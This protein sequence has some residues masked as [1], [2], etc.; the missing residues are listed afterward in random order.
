MSSS[1]RDGATYD[2]IS[3]PLERIGREV[4]ERLDLAGDETVL[5][6]GCGSGRVTEALLERVP[7]G[8]VIGVDGS[9]EMLAAA[10]RRLGERVELLEQDLEALDLGG[11]RVDA[12]L[13]TAT[14]HW[15]ADHERLFARLRG[16]LRPGGQ[17]VAQCGGAGNTPELVVA[18]RAVSER[19]PF[20]AHLAGWD[21]PWNYADP[22]ETTARLEAA[23]FADVRTWLVER[24]TPYDDLRE[25]LRTNAL[26]AHTARLPEGLREAYI[27][28]VMEALGPEG[29]I[30]YVRLN[31]DAIAA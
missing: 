31:L 22:T 9:P 18:T 25:W 21:G 8:H 28:A 12:I 30:T 20:A 15:L 5:D 1:Y 26:T 11:R 19:E 14:F 4:L 7:R 29:A 23:G 16:V 2:R 27:D 17:L 3:A 13:S 6:A 10:R 24:P